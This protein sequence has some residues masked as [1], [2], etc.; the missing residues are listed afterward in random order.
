YRAQEVV[1]L[2]SLLEFLAD[3]RRDIELAA[4]LRSPLCALP[5]ALLYAVAR[6]RGVSLWR[7]LQAAAGPAAGELVRAASQEE[8][9]ALVRATER[10]A[11]WR[12]VAGRLEVSELLGRALDE[13]GAWAALAQGLRGPQRLANVVKL[14]ELVRGYE[15]GGFRALADVAA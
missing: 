3:E 15:A 11:R 9:A 1:D 13:S 10:L 5:D 7:K 14:Q 6:Q 2:V 8:R 4:V 12:R